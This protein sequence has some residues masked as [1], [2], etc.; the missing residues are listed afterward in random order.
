MQERILDYRPT[1]DLELEEPVAGNYYPIVSSV[2]ANSFKRNLW[3]NF[4]DIEDQTQDLRFTVV[5]DRAEGTS[6]LT[7]G[8]LESILLLTMCI[9]TYLSYGAP[10]LTCR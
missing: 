4:T 1:W 9:L 2:C 6:S 10:S 5:V 8:E 7:D 3:S